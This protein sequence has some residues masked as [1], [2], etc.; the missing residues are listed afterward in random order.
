LDASHITQPHILIELLDTLRS[1]GGESA[2]HEMSRLML[3]PLGPDMVH[4]I[5]LRR[6]PY[7]PQAA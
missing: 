7:K 2:A 4:S 6:T 5:P 1:V 3:L